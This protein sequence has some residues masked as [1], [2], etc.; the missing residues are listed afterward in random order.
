[1]EIASQPWTFRRDENAMTGNYDL[2]SQTM[3]IN[4]DA[5]VDVKRIR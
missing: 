1:V 3:Q 2:L 4:A 5:N